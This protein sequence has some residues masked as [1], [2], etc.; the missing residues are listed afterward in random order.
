[1]VFTKV[2]RVEEVVSRKGEAKS[3][4]FW[5]P[6]SEV[7]GAS[8]IRQKNNKVQNM[9][10]SISSRVENVEM[11]KFETVVSLAVQGDHYLPPVIAAPV[12]LILAPVG[13]QILI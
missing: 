5:G 8:V 3:Q 12:A 9:Q 7:L 1:M 6:S 13:W 10:N 4:Q 2:I 11:G